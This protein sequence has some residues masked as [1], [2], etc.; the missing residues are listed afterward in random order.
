MNKRQDIVPVQLQEEKRA[1]PSQ[2]RK[3]N[4]QKL[5][6]RLKGV[7]SELFIYEE[8]KDEMLRVLLSELSTNENY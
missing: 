1:T 4:P 3:Q 2:S 5:V 6:A 7:N 8:I